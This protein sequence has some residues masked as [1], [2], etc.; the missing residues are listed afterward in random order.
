[1]KRMLK[2]VEIKVTEEAWEDSCGPGSRNTLIFQRAYD[3][4]FCSK[5]NQ[6]SI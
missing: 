5:R 3:F 6:Q 1:M 2:G 4:T